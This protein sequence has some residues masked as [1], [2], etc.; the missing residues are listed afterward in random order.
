MCIRQRLSVTAFRSI[1]FF[2]NVKH[3]NQ[4]AIVH[5]ISSKSLLTCR[6]STTALY[7]S[8]DYVISNK[9]ND[10]LINKCSNVSLKYSTDAKQ[11]TIPIVTYEEVKDLP[12]HP[13]KWLID[14]REPSELTE[15]GVIPTAIN[16]P[17]KNVIFS[18]CFTRFYTILLY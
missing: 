9:T 7:R 17:C 4:Y 6:Y 10:T 2:L 3:Q 8:P 1:R 11:T 5:D 12:N 14:V 18:I 13:E 15:T 16:I